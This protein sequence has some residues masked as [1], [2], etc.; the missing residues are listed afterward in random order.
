MEEKAGHGMD[1]FIQVLVDAIKES[2]GGELTGETMATLNA[3][4]IT[5]LAYDILR[6]EVMDG[7]FVQLIHNGYGPFILKNPFT[8]MMRNWGVDELATLINRMHKLY[9][10]YHEDIEVECTDDEFMAMF[11]RFPQFDDCDDTFVEN[12]EKWTAAIAF[13]IDEH[14]DLFATVE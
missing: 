10:K 11:E 5:L 12:E 1:A 4:Q 14:I 7:G 6:S 8:R 3:D 2:I 13:Y 9:N